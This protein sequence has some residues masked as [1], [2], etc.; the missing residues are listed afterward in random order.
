MSSPS[1][2]RRA[3]AVLLTLLGVAG[4]LA[5]RWYSGPLAGFVHG[6]AGNVTASFS[7]YFLATMASARTGRRH[8]LAGA[9]ALLVVEAFELLDG[10]GVLTNTYDPWDLLANALGVGVAA[11]VD[12]ALDLRCV[13]AAR[14][15]IGSPPTPPRSPPSPPRGPTG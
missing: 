10:F 4:L 11:G 2:E 3:R 8:V 7:V 14:P 6:Y 13:R 12:A 5:V 9:A 1:P 15:R